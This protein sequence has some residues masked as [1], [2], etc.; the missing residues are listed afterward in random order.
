MDIFD[1]IRVECVR[2]G[3]EAKN[4]REILVELAEAAKKCD[5]LKTYSKDQIFKALEEREKIGTTGFEKGIAIPHCALDDIDEFVVG[6]LI[7]SQGV[8]FESLDG[9]LTKVFFLIIGPKSERTKHI[10]I[11]SSISKIAN[12]PQIVEKLVGAQTISSVLGTFLSHI[13]K[14]EEVAKPMEECLFQVIVQDEGYFN[15]IL[16][17]F[18]AIVQ[19]S[20]VVIE[21]NNAGYYLHKL[22]IYSS[23]WTEETKTASRVILAVVKKD[24]MNDII[25]RIN[26]IVD[27]IEERPGVLIAVQDLIYTS[28]LIEF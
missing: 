20:V 15:D 2:I 8:D 9:E 28:G 12:I 11:L 18:S 4:K 27:R 26:L 17:T 22:P 14:R 24:L 25:R 6:V 1:Y 5:V 16:Q 3:S 19:G 21:T 10:Q 13:E 23:F 7:V